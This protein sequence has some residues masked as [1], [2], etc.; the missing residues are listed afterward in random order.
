MT[1]SVIVSLG[2]ERATL[3]EDLLCD[4]CG[5]VGGTIVSVVTF[6]Y[7]SVENLH[8]VADLSLLVIENSQSGSAI[9]ANNDGYKQTPMTDQDI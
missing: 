8:L 5:K 7:A 2:C 3:I 4:F 1:K 6:R 9:F